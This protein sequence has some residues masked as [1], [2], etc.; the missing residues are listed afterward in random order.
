M[1]VKT[2]SRTPRLARFGREERLWRV[3][4]VR[5]VLLRDKC[6]KPVKLLRGDRAVSLRYGCSRLSV[7]SEVRDCSAAS[8]GFDSS[9]CGV[10]CWMNPES[11]K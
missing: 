2:A 1:L 10:C 5:E 11:K 3:K 6:V 4:S 8:D 7:L 9:S